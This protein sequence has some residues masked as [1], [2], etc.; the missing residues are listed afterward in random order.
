MDIQQAQP[1]PPP[2]PQVK[3]DELKPKCSRCIRYSEDCIYSPIPSGPS[4]RFA[5]TTADFSGPI[6]VPKDVNNSTTELNL[7]DLELLQNWIFHAY[8]GFGDGK[9]GDSIIWQRDIPE[10]AV[11]HPFLM[12]GILAVS[13]LHKGRMK[14]EEKP[15]Y[16]ATAA[17]HQNLALPSYRYI[18]DDVVHRMDEDNC[19]A[20]LA[21]GTLTSVYAFASPHPPG[22]ILFAGLCSSTGVPEWIRMIRGKRNIRDIAKG[23]DVEGV[24]LSSERHFLESP[25]LSLSPD[26][27]ELTLLDQRIESLG[28]GIVEDAEERFIYH[29]TLM[30]LRKCFA[31]P[32]QPNSPLGFKFVIFLWVELVPALGDLRVYI[33]MNIKTESL[34]I[35][36]V[37][38]FLINGGFRQPRNPATPHLIIFNFM[39]VIRIRINLSSKY[40]FANK[41]TLRLINTMVKGKATA[42]VSGRTIAETDEY[43]V[44]EGNI[45]FPPSSVNMSYMS[46][47]D[48]STHCP[49]KGDASYYSINLDKTELKNAAWYYPDP[50]EKAKNIKDYVAFYK[51]IVTVET[52]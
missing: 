19:R 11:K 3:C 2:P 10:L 41:Q 18:V 13:A 17:Y 40:S 28:P 8:E 5:R 23:W 37:I 32:Y 49:R 25:D 34:R 47:T 14:P 50:K 52:E 48:L 26:D 21:F 38:V 22:S 4:S 45:Y 9:P 51:N 6:Q 42:T 16:L 39:N 31:M 12:R 1:P 33:L 15:H 35:K 44:V 20:I 36:H 46:K 29:E 30:L 27:G 24:F 7:G 43:E